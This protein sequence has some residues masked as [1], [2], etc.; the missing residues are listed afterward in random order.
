MDLMSSK[1]EIIKLSIVHPQ[2][3]EVAYMYQD[4]G[5]WEDPH[6]GV[7]SDFEVEQ[8]QRFATGGGSGRITLHFGTKHE[9]TFDA[10]LTATF[11]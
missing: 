8:F 3:D 10:R 11:I 1:C 7:F 2:G 9:R 4:A 6:G 5:T